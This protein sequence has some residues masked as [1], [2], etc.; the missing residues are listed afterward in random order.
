[1]QREFKRSAARMI[2]AAF[3]SRPRRSAAAIYDL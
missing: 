1:M 2:A 3:S